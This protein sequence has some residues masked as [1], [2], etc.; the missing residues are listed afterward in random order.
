MNNKEIFHSHQ[1]ANQHKTALLLYM[2][3][4]N[5]PQNLSA[6]TVAHHYQVLMFP[7]NT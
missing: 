7:H 5:S 3:V 6:W 4:G 1:E 2:P